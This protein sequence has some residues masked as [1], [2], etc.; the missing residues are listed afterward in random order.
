MSNTSHLNNPT[1][2][3]QQTC[4]LRKIKNSCDCAEA[5]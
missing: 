2:H 1:D 4:Q 5:T 3:Y